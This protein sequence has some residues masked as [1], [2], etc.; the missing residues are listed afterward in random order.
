MTSRDYPI[1]L[2]PMP[3]RTKSRATK[4]SQPA[5]PVP[6]RSESSSE[7]TA[8]DASELEFIPT[9]L[10]RPI[11]AWD[12]YLARHDGKHIKSNRWEAAKKSKSS[13]ASGKSSAASGKS[14]AA[15]GKSSAALGKAQSAAQQE[16]DDTEISFNLCPGYTRKMLMKDLDAIEKEIASGSL[17]A[18][19][20]QMYDRAMAEMLAEGSLE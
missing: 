1:V 12:I 9:I 7:S 15:S 17:N 5:T 10:H 19:I 2:H 14:S 8:S 16:I 13:A 6:D 4:K 11:D 20:E 18:A 3:R